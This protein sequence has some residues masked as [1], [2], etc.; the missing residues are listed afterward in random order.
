[1]KLD[2]DEVPSVPESPHALRRTIRTRSPRWPHRPSCT[3]RSSWPHER[4]GVY[5]IRTGGRGG[6]YLPCR[7]RIIAAVVQG[8]SYARIA[9]HMQFGRGCRCTYAH[10]GVVA[11][12]DAVAGRHVCIGPDGS[13]VENGG[14]TLCQTTNI[15][16]IASCCITRYPCGRP[17][18]R[19]MTQRYSA[20]RNGIP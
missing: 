16:I 19:C 4:H 1:M 3:L 9:H 18:T 12:D 20:C 15:C 10:I 13:G 14:R 17:E 5:P 11:K 6:E 7:A 2:A 8:T